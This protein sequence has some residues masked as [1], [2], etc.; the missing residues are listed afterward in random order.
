MSS[1]AG[2]ARMFQSRVPARQ[3]TGP[4]VH[5]I[6]SNVIKGAPYPPV[7]THKSH[8]TKQ[9]KLISHRSHLYGM[10]REP[11]SWGAVFVKHGS[12]KDLAPLSF[13][14]SL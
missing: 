5:R 4:A 12:I 13:S 6:P 8:S 2:D 1:Q 7:S 11:S 14:T 3:E 10:N 9:S